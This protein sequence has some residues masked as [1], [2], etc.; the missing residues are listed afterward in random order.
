MVEYICGISSLGS[1]LCHSFHFNVEASSRATKLGVSPVE[2]SLED[3][4][5]FCSPIACLK[6]WYNTL[7]F[8]SYF[9]TYGS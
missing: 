3:G 4:I 5:L 2:D 1:P 6:I 8:V 9:I 7:Y